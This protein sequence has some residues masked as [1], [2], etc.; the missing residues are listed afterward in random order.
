MK[1]L[2]LNGIS[3]RTLLSMSALGCLPG[4]ASQRLQPDRMAEGVVWQL[5]E[6]TL[7]LRGDWNRI[8]IH[9]LLIQWTAVNDVSYVRGSVWPEAARLPDWESISQ[10]PWARQV[11]M[12]LAGYMD[13]AAARANFSSLVDISA[14][15]A[16]LPIPL[17]VVGWYFP[18]EVDSSWQ[19]VHQL[20]PLLARLPRPLWLSLYDNANVGAHTLGLWLGEWLPPDVGIFFQ[21]SVGVHAR[22]AQVARQH[23]EVLMQYLGN[24]R[25]RVI[26]EAF[27]P[28]AGGGFRAAT[29]TE[30]SSQLQHY[31][32]L[33]V[34]LFDGPHYLPPTLIEE[35]IMT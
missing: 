13:E 1:S 7:D 16:L 22:T 14:Q 10:Q 32:G 12:G 28:Q 4:G 26:A 19:D 9:N 18:V 11:I 2:S 3:R 31:E 24:N 20:A 34:Y 35:L 30:L 29:A 6:Q 23:A 17:N 5:N 33:S 25:L 27:R 15:L 21:D 8:G